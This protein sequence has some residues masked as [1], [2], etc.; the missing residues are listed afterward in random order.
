MKGAVKKVHRL[1]RAIAWLLTAAIVAGNLSQLSVTTAYASETAGSR[2]ESSSNAGKASPSEASPSE[3]SPTGAARIIDVYVTQSAIE[4]VLKKDSDS[5]PELNEDQI[6]FEGDQK[7]LVLGKLYEE[8]EGKTLVIQKKV[9]KAMYLVVVSDTLA[10]E[11][12]FE[13]DRSERIMQESVLKNIQVIGVNGYKDR[14]CE[15]RLRIKGDDLMITDAHME[16]F[17]VKGENSQEEKT[18]PPSS[19]G[20]QSGSSGSSGTAGSQQSAVATEEETKI[21]ET[22]AQGTDM[23]ETQDQDN[24]ETD[25]NPTETADGID[26]RTGEE[27]GNQKDEKSG[28]A[29][30]ESKAKDGEA[31]KEDQD[32]GVR[33]E[34]NGDSGIDSGEALSVSSSG[35]NGISVRRHEVP[36]LFSSED[37]LATASEAEDGSF[38]EA[39]SF[40]GEEADLVSIGDAKVLSEE[41][42]A[43]L[44]GTDVAALRGEETK[45][46]LFSFLSQPSFGM[47]VRSY[48]MTLLNTEV[49]SEGKLSPY[50]TALTYYGTDA[51]D[52]KET[53]EVSLFQSQTGSIKAGIIYNYTITY[54]MQASPLYEYA[55]GG[56][57]SL[58]DE[59]E[60]AKILFTVPAGIAIEEQPGKVKLVSSDDDGKVYEIR[61]GDKNNV[62]CPSKSDSITMNAYIDG[63]GE[64]AV[65][66]S[67]SLSKNSIAFYADVKV[68]DKTDKDHV[69]Y[70]GNIKTITYA[71][72]P[73]DTTLTLVSDD[74]WHIKKRVY[75]TD[76]SYTVVNDSAGNPEFVDIT[77]LIEMGMYASSGVIS[78]QPSGTIYQTY[79]RTGFKENTFKITDSLKI[80]TENAP[81]AMKPI[82]VTARW[83]DGPAIQVTQK[84]DQ[85]IIIDEF[86]TQGQNGADHIYVSDQAPTYSAYLVTAR[87]PYAPFLLKYNDERAGKNEV[88]TVHN[89]AHLEYIKLGTKQLVTE[90][91][92]AN[93][94]IH[95]V[96]QPAVIKIRKEIEEGLGVTQKYGL[97]MEKEYPGMAGFEI[98]SLDADNKQVPYDNYTVIDSAGQKI[99]YKNIIVNPSNNE[100]ESGFYETGDHGYIQIQVDPGTYVI[101][102]T[103]NP[104][105]T[106]F[107]SAKVGTNPVAIGDDLKVTVKAGENAEVTVVNEVIGKGAIE[108]YKKA[109]TWN[110]VTTADADLNALEGA[111]FT[112]YQKKGDGSLTEVK[113]VTSDSKGCVLFKP[114]S[115]DQYVVREKSANGYILDNHDY[116]VTVRADV[117][118]P[119]KAGD[120][121]LVNKLNEAKVS[122]M[123]LMQDDQ[124]GYRK[125][126]AAY[127][128][129]FKEKFWIEKN[130]GGTWINVSAVPEVTYSLDSESQFTVTL[131][132]Y[133]GNSQKIQ[134]R[135]AEEVPE[136]YSD[137]NGSEAGFSQEKRGNK[138]YIY[139]TFSLEPLTTTQVE[140][141]NNKGG[142]LKLQ[143]EAWSISSGSLNKNAS[144]SGYQFKLYEKSGDTYNEV[145]PGTIYTTDSRGEIVA[146]GLDVT[147]EYYWSEINSTGRLEAEDSSKTVVLGDQVF[148]GPY[149]VK[150]ESDAWAKAYNIPQKIPYWLYKVDITDKSKPLS[151][152]FQITKDRGTTVVYDNLTVSNTGT[153]VI[154]DPGTEYTIKETI[155]PSKYENGPDITVKTPDK[156]VT[157]TQLEDWF[158]P[159]ST[160]NRLT[161]ENKPY[162]SV[163]IQKT[164]YDA[165]G[166][167]NTGINTITFRAYAK[168][169]GRFKEK[170][171]LKS[172]TA[173][174]LAPNTYYFKEDVPGGNIKPYFL[175]S[176]GDRT[177]GAHTGYEVSGTDIYYGPIDITAASSSNE[178]SRDLFL[179]ESKTP[180][181]NYK[182]NGKV[183][184]TKKDA[185]RDTT[186]NGAVFGI[187]KASEFNVN[188]W[189]ASIAKPIQKLTTNN[190]GQVTFNSTNLKIFDSNG[191]RISYVIAEITPPSNYLPSYEIL[192]TTLKEGKVITT[193]NGEENGTPLVIKNEPKLTI[194]TQK[195]WRDEWNDHFYKVDHVLGNVKLALYKG[196]ADGITADYVK[197]ETTNAYDGIATFYEIDR[198]DTYYVVEVRVPT[199][200]ET[201]FGFDLNMK[202]KTPLVQGNEAPPSTLSISDLRAGKY[203]AVEY[204]GKDLP[205]NAS[206]YQNTG[207]LYNY[208]PWVQFHV[209]KTCDGKALNGESHPEETINGAKFTLYKMKGEERNLSGIQL[210]DL[211]DEGRFER[212]DGYESGTRVDPKTGGRANGEFDT[213]ILETGKVYWLVE[214]EAAPG[215]Q[216]PGGRQIV[217]V[218]VPE[219]SGYTGYGDMLHPYKSGRKEEITVVK[220]QHGDGPG[221]LDAYYFQIKLNKWLKDAVRPTAEPTLL[222]G[223][224]FQIWLLDPDSEEK[225]LPVEVVETGLE[226]D[227]DNKTGYALSKMINMGKLKESL[228]G[229]GF[230]EASIN[231]ILKLEN[232]NVTALFGLEEVYAPSKVQMDPAL[233]VL[234]AT[235]PRNQDFVQDQYFWEPGDPQ[236]YRLMNTVLEQYPVTLAKYG[237]IPDS[238]TFD[239]TDEELDALNINKTPLSGVKF[240][241]YQN[242]WANGT[243]SYKSIGTYTTDS[244]GRIKLPMGLK[245]GRYRLKETLTS[246]QQQKY[247]TMY[248]GKDDLWR[249][250]TVGSYPSTVNV[251]NPEKPDLVIEKTTWAG[252]PT[253][254]LG[255]ITFA[256]QKSGGSEISKVTAKLEDGRYAASFTNL[257]SGVYT[258]KAE[259]LGSEAAKTVTSSYFEPTAVNV[260]YEAKAVGERVTLVPIGNATGK[261]ATTTVKNPR[262]ADLVIHKV[263]AET[264]E[265]G[266]NMA[267]ASFQVEYLKFRSGTDLIGGVLQ[268]VTDEGYTKPEHGFTV[269]GTLT[270]NKDGSYVMKNCEPGWY[271]ITEQKAPAGYTID[272]RPMIVAVA[273]D[274]AGEY[275]EIHSVTFENR[276]KA[277]L[278]VTKK[279]FFG[280]GFINDENIADKLPAEIVFDIYTYS[281]NAYKQVLDEGS[282][283]VQVKIRNFEVQDGYYTAGGTALLPQMPE[284]GAYYLKEQENP[285]WMLTAFGGEQNGTLQ[286]DGYIKVG[287]ENDFNSRNPVFITVNNQYAKSRI[288]LNKID[289]TDHTKKLTGAAFKL[290]S[291]PQLTKEVGNFTEIGQS[292]VY[293]IVFSTKINS[294]GTYYI[295]EVNA[296]AGYMAITTAIPAEGLTAETGKTTEITVENQGG[297]DLQIT[298]YSGNGSAESLRSGICFEL[299]RRSPGGIWNYVTEGITDSQGSLSFRGLELP[300]GDSYGVHEVMK[301]ENGFDTFR[302]DSFKGAKGTILPTTADAIKN[303]ETKSGIGLYVLTGS[304]T[305]TPGVYGFEAHNQEALP[306]KLIKNDVNKQ[307]NPGNSIAVTM[308]IMNKETGSQVGNTVTV[309]YGEAGTTVALLPGIYVIEE[310][311]VTRNNQ[312]Y[313]INKDDS[314]TV[315][316]KEV[317]VKKG[318]I[319]DPCEFTNVKQKTGVTL[320]K[321]SAT[322]SFK[323]LWWHE[324]QTVTY[325]LTPQGINSIPLDGFAVTDTGLRMLDAGKNPLSEAEYT[326]EAYTITGVKP[327]KA[328]EQNRIHG[329]KTGTIMADVTFY[330]FNG[331]QAGEVQSVAVSGDGEIGAVKPVTGIM[332][333]SFRISYRDDTLKASTE[334]RYV[335]GNDFV[336][337]SIDVTVKLNRQNA[338][339]PDGSFKK[340]IKFIRNE[341]EVVM[342]YRMWDMNGNLV[343]GQ[344][345]SQ[346][347]QVCDI[348][349]VQSQAPAISVKKEVDPINGIQPRDVLTYSLYV[350]NETTNN[351]PDIA[352]LQKPILIDYVPLGVTVSG[353]SDGESRLLKAVTL[354]E[355]PKGVVIEKTIKKVDPQTGRESL[356]IQL[357]GALDQGESV[358]VEVKAQIAGSIINYGK[359][360]LNELYVTSDVL[361]PAFSLNQTGASFMIKTD[362]GSK[363][364][365]ADLPKDVQLPDEKYRSYGYASD[366]AQNTMSTGSGLLLHKAVKGNLDTRFVSG[367]TVGKVAKSAEDTG[368]TK[369]DGSVLYRL[370]VN[371]ASANDYITQL[372]L[373]DILPAPGD[374]STGNFNRISDYRLKF[375]DIVSIVIENRS[376]STVG[377]K[378][379]NFIYQVTYSDETFHN[380][381]TAQQGKEAMLNDNQDGFWSGRSSDPTAI[382]IKITDDKFYLAPGENLVVTY[383]TVVPYT[384]MKELDE[385]AYGYAVNDFATS[386]SYKKSLT[387]TSEIKF[388]QAQT[389]NAVQVV[390]VPGNVKVSGRV[391]I[392]DNNNGI[393]DESIEQD[394]LLT[395]LLPVLQSEYFKANLLKYS[396]YGDD[397]VS[398]TVG[399]S[400]A[401]FLFDGLTPAK[402]FGITGSEFAPDQ[403]NGWYTNQS[404]I[405]SKLKGEDPAHYRII[406]TTGTMPQGYEDLVLKLAEPT[407]LVS[408]ENAE[409]GRSRLPGTLAEGGRNFGESR[410]SNFKESKGAYAS[411]DFFLWS[412]GE[413]YDKTKDIGFV[414]FRNVTIKKINEAGNPVEGAH[415]SVYGPYT[416]EEMAA[417]RQNGI[418]SQADLG[419]PAAQGRTALAGDEAV[420][421][422]GELLY[423]RNYIVIEDEAPAGYEI[424]NAKTGDMV[425]MASYKG[426]GQKAWELL[427]KEF[428]T[429]GNPITSAVT[430]TNSY[431]T[432]SLEF[433]KLDGLTK[434]ELGGA[435]FRIQKKDEVVE[436]AWK[437]F[438]EAMKKDPVSMG[439]TK[440][441]A[442]DD[443]VEFEV[444]SGK[445]ALTGI[446]YG[447]YTLSEIRVPDGYDITK[448]QG[449]V[450]FRIETNGQKAV[451]S[452]L[453]GNL[454]QN[455]RT[456]YSLSL[457]K[458]DNAGNDKVAGIRFAITGPGKYESSSWIPFSK[459]SFK[460]NDPSVSGYEVKQTDENGLIQWNLP[461]G[462]YRLE[463]LEGAGYEPVEPFYVRI[464][465]N[466]AVS[467]L[468][469]EGRSELTLNSSEQN[470]INL[471]IKNVIKTG[472]LTV[473]KVD[474]ETK[475]AITGAMFELSGTSVINGAFEA[476]QNHVTGLGVSGVLAGN[477]D[478]RLWIRFQV[479]GT[480]AS[481]TGL[482]TQIPYG[483]YTLKEIK[484]PDGYLF[485]SGREWTKDFTINSSEGVS[486]TGDHGVVNTPHE[487]NIEK[488]DQITDEVLPDAVFMLM[489]ADGKYVSLDENNSY[490]GLKQSQEEGSSFSTGSDGRVFV[491]RL[492]AGSYRLKEIQAPANYGVAADT[493]ITVLQSGNT[494][495]VKVYD[496]RN[497]ARIRINKAASHNHEMRL[498]G[499]IFEIYSDKDLTALAGTMTTGYD[500]IGE[501]EM[502]PL[503]TYYVKEQKA[504]A[505]YELS[506]RVYEVTLLNER[507]SYPV[508]A[509]GNDFVTNDYGTGYLAFDKVD[510]S[511]G[512]DIASARFSLTRKET[513]VD[514]AFE[515]FA[516]AL[517]NMGQRSLEAMGI[518]DVETESGIIRFTSVNGHVDMKGIPYGTYTLKE[519]M[520][521]KGYL[522]LNGKAEFEFT[523]TEEQRE[524]DL[525]NSNKVVNERAQF[526]LQLKKVDHLGNSVSGIQF[527]I[528]GPG[529]YEENGVLSMFGANRF[530]TDADS[531]TGLFTTGDNGII[532][533]GLKHGDYRIREIASHRY[534][535]IEPFYIRIDREGKG[536]ILKDNSNA[537]AIS[538]DALVTVT[539]TNKVSTGYLE[540]EK[541]D[542]ENNGK[543]LEGAEFELTNLSTLVPG[544][545]ESY[546]HQAAAEGASWTADQVV[547]NTI[548]FVLNGKGAITNLPYGT[549]RLTE[550]KAPDGYLLGTTPW[551]AEFSVNDANKEIR[552]TTPGLFEKTKGAIV[553]MP[554]KILVVKTNG[555][556]ADVK[557][558]GAEF[559]LKASDG[560]YVKL[561][562]GSFAGYT[563]DKAAAGTFVTDNDGQFVLKRLPKD[564]YTFL[565][566]KAPAGYYIN[567]H[568]PP[569]TLDGVN[570]FTI[571][572]QDERI[573]GGGGSSGGPS[574]RDNPGGPGAAVTILPD[575]IPLANLPADG[576][577]DLLTIDDG[578]V[579]LANLPKTGDRQKAAGK[580]MVAL[581]GFMMALY[582]A[583]SK[584]KKEN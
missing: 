483:S 466:G 432:G 30:E 117:T 113:T 381:A 419:S 170:G 375:E 528:L 347:K 116:E 423:Y 94:A 103:I 333:K 194:R 6:P 576:S 283:P 479:D 442:T 256:I 255:G 44:M 484:A 377:R 14:D 270:D 389:S 580:V 417:F 143:K 156:P 515:H 159:S 48:G 478:G 363:W 411:E 13:A 434:K 108:F 435:A 240:E 532:S 262:L 129:D 412:A 77:Y 145:L 279:L 544:A 468:N 350:K 314:R 476:Y 402:P 499:A 96:N 546:R 523:V 154:L 21:Q 572:I 209:I 288:R 107:N 486:L 137:G 213:A 190:N 430:V 277:E 536:S 164:Q 39:V 234:K 265:S 65:G 115:P 456:E 547:G 344:E 268:N 118:S 204:T 9:G 541:V 396:K 31:E 54:T 196:N 301:T 7:D 538:N 92:E 527:E 426:K 299:Y 237:Y 492:P 168:E 208:K 24:G 220:N 433:T 99:N 215:Y 535:A 437:A 564:T 548:T 183:T 85:S 102:E 231:R 202:D 112:L 278:T 69:T 266:S 249:Y 151:A 343:P 540:M 556:Y 171:I 207:A 216:L 258:V 516:E 81:E 366:S 15:F 133:D 302:M 309:P 167:A 524:A 148:I 273:A 569:L 404:L 84:D 549:Y 80:L 362:S 519:E 36:V 79:G 185:L 195:V 348:P 349:V 91:S 372:Q 436:D 146:K 571:T 441:I 494:E 534:D 27:T 451:L 542:G 166:K 122:V 474:G 78:R 383:K 305:V 287:G 226:S 55:A 169:E 42:R 568:I 545:W 525:G 296:P 386:F 23:E 399:L 60:N 235:I 95:Q 245:A 206:L 295:K 53:A 416:N 446:P 513:R 177:Q 387:D 405:V 470:Q 340:D 261:V 489:T 307:D 73:E 325:T 315:Y 225:L 297:I 147:R 264:K 518:S 33:E 473:E 472:S 445:A 192:T 131:P 530:T 37:P 57:L 182:D 304:N 579:P 511:T 352:K 310:T 294:P 88:F 267:G 554:S 385:V 563:D 217:A 374:Y 500:G 537:A 379:D 29:A 286:E 522:S 111:E 312:G 174:Q 321:T 303:G 561:D 56:K 223:A 157:K 427:S 98:Y 188:D 110:T 424:A 144:K 172:N 63:N 246:A 83:E 284:G 425:P 422:A 463:E 17:A 401:R 132:V 236:K 104:V 558:N 141:K 298:K 361:Q 227:N 551:T 35:S 257:E 97:T 228:A 373:M 398:G 161:F 276:K 189:A 106:Q 275:E 32:H 152:K 203:N 406:V 51:S 233:H 64:R 471:I 100:S 550:K 49:D 391:W 150:R 400:D 162:Q 469:G 339:L 323:D 444:V 8:L 130:A 447:T 193:V 58:F 502:L 74:A 450:E 338:K 346:A 120:N 62:I 175:L 497:K 76:D 173:A 403:E 153:F 300:A 82:S 70:P 559:I 520:A 359:N 187:F 43:A 334:N 493:E 28:E 491:K 127:R 181:L 555:V 292:G 567:N 52:E 205:Q 557:L 581:S 200:E 20:N 140:L 308:K 368:L 529:R 252:V 475:E 135:V 191:N 163:A 562:N 242:Q 464:S 360:I 429:N 5:R 455:S 477:E 510:G 68:A 19:A 415:F 253:V 439:V 124:G 573:R 230:E 421:N 354:K 218:F 317:E 367:T 318:V 149:R 388:T 134:Y 316:R 198:R 46:S 521:P 570:S 539:V 357:N 369:H 501:S 244:Y 89:K 293:D 428:K 490:T 327:G 503:G 584:K 214:E 328:T 201:G 324:G 507:E 407:M 582:A 123:K 560:R 59:Y 514:G 438:T 418:R 440:V 495:T 342:D 326:N 155:P 414:P 12:F 90:D 109:R 574:G 138:T 371:N 365:S 322:T 467:L 335:L 291:D 413:D 481:K 420:W 1:R 66:E 2:S 552:Y 86:K 531:D 517:G 271:R 50:E 128:D 176:D 285:D 512:E 395:D 577:V 578:N 250:F 488:R 238:S 212:V 448:K 280:D 458:T 460:Q 75:P 160:W 351:D 281:N 272:A 452:G 4:K 454:I 186:V 431:V 72:Q 393:Q 38:A 222:G 114:L 566:T 263:D 247:I 45:T 508:L 345:K 453:E 248:N 487:L 224:K 449:D 443:E 289:G 370:T 504:P 105:G 71:Q 331:S 119:I 397:E 384:T 353:E 506:G 197:T 485:S 364:P 219:E 583:F 22:D 3:A 330:D 11:P 61:V 101:K 575:Q 378:V 410:D 459:A 319:P 380:K 376:D 282:R 509:D 311:A 355:A 533:L 136:G 199:R 260:G 16:E 482:L 25:P 496:V 179:A 93:I 392:D 358:T 274:M 462:D 329:A 178:K 382:R 465:G 180:L 34:N 10:G 565:E 337:G 341:A 269:S 259:S 87:Y 408:G 290:Y 40:A 313:V 121:V 320:N 457:K 67:F 239:K 221:G 498:D 336:P 409:A 480:E 356:F 211:A 26:N 254:S 390:L 139:K 126:P 184:V 394:H 543:R 505:G 241:I 18:V 158:A 47:V 243:Y 232:E 41:E 165:D 210:S 332:V 461:Y 229:K 526:E 251:Y 306:L 553:N 125:V 142:T